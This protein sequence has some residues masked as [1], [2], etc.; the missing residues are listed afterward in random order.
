MIVM[1]AA[2]G[3]V[4]V[5]RSDDTNGLEIEAPEGIDVTPALAAAGLG[6]ESASTLHHWLSID[7]LRELASS[8][9]TGPDWSDRWSGMIAFAARHG[10]TN[11]DDTAVMA[12]LV[13]G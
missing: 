11:D 6:G 9:Q 3:A 8:G 10:W 1:I 2:D 13:R 12:H 4:E 7:V 5:I